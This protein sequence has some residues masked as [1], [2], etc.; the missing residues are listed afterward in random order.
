M[1]PFLIEY[2][3][4]SVPPNMVH[5]LLA[6]LWEHFEVHIFQY[7]LN[8]PLSIWFILRQL[9]FTFLVLSFVACVTKTSLTMEETIK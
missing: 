6:F 8:L 3:F 2:G 1:C 5:V 9:T 7:A 4:S